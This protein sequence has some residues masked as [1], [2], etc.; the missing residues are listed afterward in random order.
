MKAIAILAITLAGLNCCTVATINNPAGGEATYAALG[1]DSE[2][3]N[4]TP[5]G[6]GINTN[7]NSASFTKAVSAATAA[8][9][10]VTLTKP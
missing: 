3:V 4:I 1:S 5:D 8:T 6:I 2:G 10:L 7:K 9:G